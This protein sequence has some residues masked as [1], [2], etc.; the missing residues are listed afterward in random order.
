MTRRRAIHCI[1]NESFLRAGG[2]DGGGRGR[3]DSSQPRWT[4]LARPVD[5]HYSRVARRFVDGSTGISQLDGTQQ[6]D[7][8]REQPRASLRS[9][10]IGD[11]LD[12]GVDSRGAGCRGFVTAATSNIDFHV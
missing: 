3:E 2:H 5:G 7:I 9:G 11:Q 1:T 10:M 12:N 8:V 4:C 6:R